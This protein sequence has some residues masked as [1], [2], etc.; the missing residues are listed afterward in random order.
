MTQRKGL[1]DI[2]EAM[3]LLKKEP[4]TLSVL[5]QPSMPLEF[6]HKKLSNF[7]YFSPRANLDVQKVMLDHDALV[8]P[9]IIEG[10]ALVQQEALA[11]GLPIIVTRNAGAEDLIEEGITGHEVP[12]RSPNKIAEAITMLMTSKIE[13]NE[14]RKACQKKAE[15]YQWTEYAKK[16]IDFNLSRIA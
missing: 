9:S 12:I 13:K 15:D 7:T 4:V 3:K 10:R 8:L 2:F 11:C 6:Y 5:G 16:I 1:A 14:V